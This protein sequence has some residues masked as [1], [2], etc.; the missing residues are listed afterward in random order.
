MLARA[1][2]AAMLRASQA[3]TNRRSDVRSSL[4]IN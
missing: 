4:R 3:S 2:A 1:A